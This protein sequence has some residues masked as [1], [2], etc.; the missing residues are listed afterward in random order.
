[1][2]KAVFIIALLLILATSGCANSKNAAKPGNS[3][4][5]SVMPVESVA[6]PYNS[7]ATGKPEITPVPSPA[8][9][10]HSTVPGIDY[11]GKNIG[12]SVSDVSTAVI[13]IPQS[14]QPR[15][16]RKLF[17]LKDGY[18]IS[19]IDSDRNSGL[20]I[21]GSASQKVLCFSNASNMEEFESGNNL[22]IS[23]DKS[24]V[25]YVYPCAWEVPGSLYIYDINGSKL[26]LT[27]DSTNQLTPKFGLWLTP[28]YLLVA[29]CNTYGTA[30]IG[31][32]F[33]FDSSTNKLSLSKKIVTKNTNDLYYMQDIKLQGNNISV[34]LKHYS[35]SKEYTEN[36]N[37]DINDLLGNLN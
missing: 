35:N 11:M 10:L 15:Q 32:L 2:K 33:I 12:Y 8:V 3:E 17:D 19:Y 13:S 5:I 31:N 23:P 20:I 37:F 36:I 24:R 6:S 29:L 7:I 9:L 27:I 26:K 1:M 34:N 16:Q 21:N 25:A 22:S 30:R 28:R 14:L 4:V 18:S